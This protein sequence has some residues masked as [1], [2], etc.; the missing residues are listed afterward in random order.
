[1]EVSKFGEA[2]APSTGGTNLDLVEIAA[3]LIVE[4]RKPIRHPELEM[5]PS[6]GRKCDSHGGKSSNG[7]RR[8]TSS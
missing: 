4:L 8:H 1:M 2:C 7:G 6:S 5:A 3:H